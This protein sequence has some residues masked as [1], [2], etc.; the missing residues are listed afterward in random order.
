MDFILNISHILFIVYAIIIG[1][2]GNI[3][4]RAE[5]NLPIK[6]IWLR[7]LWGCFALAVYL[8]ALQKYLK[9]EELDLINTFPIFLLGFL[10]EMMAKIL[11]DLVEKYIKNKAGGNNEKK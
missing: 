9:V 4:Y 5:K 10:S 2:L 3:T 8:T 1:S 11:P 7:V 6:P